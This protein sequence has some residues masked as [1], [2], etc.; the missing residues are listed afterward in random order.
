MHMIKTQISKRP[1]D[2]T[3]GVFGKENLIGV[4]EDM[5]TAPQKGNVKLNNFGFFQTHKFI[6]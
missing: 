5:S 2:S 4:F 3:L 1:L 6:K